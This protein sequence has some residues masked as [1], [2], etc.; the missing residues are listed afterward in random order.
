MQSQYASFFT[1]LS[2]DC[3]MVGLR[4]N[5]EGERATADGERQLT[6]A[7]RATAGRDASS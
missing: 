3:G 6:D 2:V 1:S 4:E 5:S 7:G